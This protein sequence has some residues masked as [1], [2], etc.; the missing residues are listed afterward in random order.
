MPSFSPYKRTIDIELHSLCLNTGSVRGFAS[1]GSPVLVPD[2]GNH[3]RAAANPQRSD[4]DPQLG[5][6]VRAVERPRDGERLVSLS[7]NARY[8]CKISLVENIPAE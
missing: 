1:V 4:D 2:G 7:H 8:L 5:S 6:D 3:Q